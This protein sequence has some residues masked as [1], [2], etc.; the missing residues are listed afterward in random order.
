MSERRSV[1]SCVPLGFA[2][3]SVLFY[4][5]INDSDSGIKCTLRK[6][7]DDT[8]MCSGVN[9]PD[10]RDAIQMDLGRLEQWAQENLIRFNKSKCEVLYLGH[11]N[12][13]ITVQAER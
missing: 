3:G 8:K 10:G 7:A 9:T 11:D 2:L 5:F 13:P 12:P 6:F 1:T 4:I